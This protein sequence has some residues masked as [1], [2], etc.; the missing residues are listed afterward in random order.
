[1]QQRNGTE[2]LEGCGAY[3]DNVV[4]GNTSDAFFY[5]RKAIPWSSWS[6]FFF[7]LRE[8]CID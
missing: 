4:S 2:D 7:E 3:V 1:M 8:V 6:G 5:V